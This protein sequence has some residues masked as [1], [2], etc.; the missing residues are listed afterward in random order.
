MKRLEKA[1]DSIKTPDSWKENLYKAA[2]AESTTK[3]KK[4]SVK[5][6]ISVSFAAAAACMAS[7]LTVGAITGTFNIVE[8]LRGNFRDEISAE[9]YLK[10]QYQELDISCEN[11]NVLFEALAFM[12][13]VNETYTLV[14][15]RPKT[16]MEFDKMSIEVSVLENT[17]TNLDEYATFTINSAAETDENGNPVYFFNVRN[18]PCC[19][20]YEDNSE[21]LIIRISEITYINNGMEMKEFVD[22]SMEYVPDFTK[23]SQI[24]H[25]IFEEVVDINGVECLFE[26]SNISDYTA[27]IDFLYDIPD[28][29]ELN[30]KTYVDSENISNLMI[31]QILNLKSENAYEP[32]VEEC[33]VK[34]IVDGKI[35]QFI[36]YNE[37]TMHYPYQN[38]MMLCGE[39]YDEDSSTYCCQLS[40]KPFK[41]TEAESVEFQIETTNG[42]TKVLKVK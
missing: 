36:D 3:Q 16:D 18:L 37:E 24:E 39:N 25:S 35:K 12:G 38:A 9:K 7:A 41:L 22:L 42:E 2:Y 32:V 10:G 14:T 8:I 40:F 20:L 13:D 19:G 11:E 15:A 31:R 29:L 21:S 33:P 28:T 26:Y 27:T 17:I 5:R 1:F 6:V 34:L 30:E 23:I 4:I